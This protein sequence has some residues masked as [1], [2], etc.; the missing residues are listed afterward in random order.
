M[1][2]NKGTL[3]RVRLVSRKTVEHMTSDHVPPGY[4][5]ANPIQV[6]IGWPSPSV[7]TGQGYGLG[8]G[9][10][11]EQDRN[12]LP[13]SKGMYYWTGLYGTSFWIDPKEQLIAIMMNQA[14]PQM[15]PY[16]YRMRHYVYGAISD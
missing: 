9:I 7:E 8:F 15:I 1:F 5:S 6:Q 4:K 3:D 12:P 16:Q 14:P 11:P 10:S 13:G 2:L